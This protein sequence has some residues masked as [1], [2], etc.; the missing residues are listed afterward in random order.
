MQPQTIFVC[1]QTKVS[2]YVFD[3][4]D[5]PISFANIIFKGSTQGTITNENGKFYLESDERTKIYA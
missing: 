4:F 3:E 2:G 1:A 5:A